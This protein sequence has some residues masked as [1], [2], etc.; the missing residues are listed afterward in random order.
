MVFVPP[1][2]P[3]SRPRERWDFA[4]TPPVTEGLRGGAVFSRNEAVGFRDGG[5]NIDALGEGRRAALPTAAR[6]ERS[7]LLLT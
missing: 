4:A 5:A 3:L 1:L 6:A 7:G 2:W